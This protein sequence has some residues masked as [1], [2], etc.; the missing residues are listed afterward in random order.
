MNCGLEKDV[1]EVAPHYAEKSRGALYIG[2]T[3]GRFHAAGQLPSSARRALC[4]PARPLGFLHYVGNGQSG[5]LYIESDPFQGTWAGI[6]GCGYIPEA[7]MTRKKT[8]SIFTLG[9][10]LVLTA[11]GGGGGSTS[12]ST[13]GT[14]DPVTPTLSSLQI[15]PA[16]ISVAP[17]A[18]Q[19]FKATGSYS[20]G[21]S[22]DLTA[23]VQWN[24]SDGSVASVSS[25]GFATAVSTGVATLTASSGKMQGLATFDV[26]GAAANLVS[27]S[28]TPA[29]SSLPVNT[30]QQ[31]TATGTYNDG[32][33]SDLTAV[34]SW[35]SSANSIAKIDLAGL[36]SGVSAGPATISAKLGSVTGSTGL[37]VTAPTIASIVVTPDDLTLGIGIGQ[38]YT[39][40]AV[41]S[42]GST[43]DLT[44]GV[45]WSSSAG[46][47]ASINGV[48]L[49]TTAGAG[50]ATITATV[51]SLTDTTTVTVV[52]AHLI[53]IAVSPSPVSLA[54]GTAQQFAATGTFDDGSTQLLT[55]VTWSSV[56]SAIATV[57]TASGW[58]TAV[59][60]GSTSVTATSGA[61]SGSAAVT[62]TGATLVS[63]AVTPANSTMPSGTTKQ[64]TATGTFSDSSTQDI[65]ASALWSSST[66]AAA[67]INNQGLVSSIA[68]GVTTI[69]A[70]VGSVSGSTPL[71]VS[72]VKLVSIAIVPANP[73]IQRHTTIKFTA[74]GTFSDGSTGANL[75]GLVWTASPPRTASM[76][77]AGLVFGKKSGTATITASSGG[78]KGT[79]TLTVGSGTLTSIAV[80]PVNASV[81]VGASQQFT[82]TGAYSDGTHQDITSKAHWSS[83]HAAVATIA[84][85]P[86]VAGLA[87]T[88]GVGSTVIGANSGGTS[89]STTL[90]VH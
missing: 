70:S 46:S 60:T 77:G 36:A 39:A 35:S 32:S 50:T 25:S 56:N 51:G 65:T 20:D 8:A 86:S 5:D 53:S 66:P 16:R 26:T 85:A 6:P 72:A 34:V 67:I 27:V 17:G 29:A 90:S 84:N 28:V 61:V 75:A 42:D 45:T 43:Q 74:V 31:Y 88:T 48:G 22:K 11:C 59:G 57:N 1:P 63:L 81:A 21:S 37:T 55:S 68:N 89:A 10:L 9:V 44:S 19:Q 62:V 82:A 41:Y 38:Q 12:N 73:R 79:T 23:T 2:A 40:T 49:L 30:S 58:A 76:R 18:S 3:P 14:P 83:S 54:K 52:A 64:M 33:T 24:S 13:G 4:D 15:S 69:T 47:V 7:E 71:T 78:V 80:T 87:T